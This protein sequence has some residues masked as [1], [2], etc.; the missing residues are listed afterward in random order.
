MNIFLVNK[1]VLKI[2]INHWFRKDVL[3]QLI[4]IY[5]VPFQS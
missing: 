1:I 5:Q 2:R 3:K 4:Q